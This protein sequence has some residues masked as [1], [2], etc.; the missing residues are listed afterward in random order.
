MPQRVRR[1]AD[2]LVDLQAQVLWLEQNRNEG[3]IL[4]LREAV[5]EATRALARFPTMGAPVLGHPRGAA[6]EPLR[7]LVLRRI[8][9]VVW[10]AVADDGVWL[11]R[12]FHARQKRPHPKRP[13]RG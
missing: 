10:Y 13:R 12:L 5:D 3:W 6:A 11:L 4:R 2:F 8:P 7:K 1:H 9:F